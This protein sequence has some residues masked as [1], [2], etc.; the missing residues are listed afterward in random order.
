MIL[1]SSASAALPSTIFFIICSSHTGLLAVLQV[2]QMQSHH[3]AFAL[4]FPLLAFPTPDLP[5]ANS[6]SLF[7]SRFKCQLLKEVVS[8]KLSGI[9]QPFYYAHRFSEPGV[10][11]GQCEEACLCCMMSGENLKIRSDLMAKGWTHP[12]VPLLTWLL[13]G[14]GYCLGSQL[15]CWPEHLLVASPCGLCMGRFGLPHSIV[16]W[17]QE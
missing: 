7:W 14:V 1:S 6:S 4:A 15:G 8:P 12:K 3:A 16:A 2:L 10:Q 13:V 5:I 9:K 17:F 11:T